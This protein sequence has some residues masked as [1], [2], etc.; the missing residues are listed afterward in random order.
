MLFVN[1]FQQ[2]ESA[3]GMSLCVLGRRITSYADVF[4]VMWSGVNNSK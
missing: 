2:M 1:A 3:N 4:N